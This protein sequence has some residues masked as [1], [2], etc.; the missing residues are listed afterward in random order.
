MIHLELS[1]RQTDIRT[2]TV[3][4]SVGKENIELVIISI[5]VVKRLCK[6]I[7][8]GVARGPHRDPCGIP[9]ERK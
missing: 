2:E 3:R 1:L 5:K 9:V 7:T 4:L 6:W 8:E